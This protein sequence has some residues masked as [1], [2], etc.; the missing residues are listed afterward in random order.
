MT[1]G[2]SFVILLCATVVTLG[3]AVFMGITRRLRFHVPLVLLTVAFLALT[4][5]QA[6]QLGARY[7]LEGTGGIYP[8]HLFMAR[9]TAVAL[10]LPV[11]AGVAALLNRSREALHRRLAWFAL[12]LIAATTITG[13]VMMWRAEPLP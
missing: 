2:A 11:G 5:R 8:V 12:V 1:A 7:D 9:L 13:V 4:I 3:V 6:L 10:V